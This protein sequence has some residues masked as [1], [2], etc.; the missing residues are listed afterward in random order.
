MVRSLVKEYQC[1]KLLAI[2]RKDSGKIRLE[3]KREKGILIEN[4]FARNYRRT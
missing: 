3:G 4:L 2:Y 1:I